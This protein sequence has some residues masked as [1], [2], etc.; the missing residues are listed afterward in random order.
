VQIESAL[1]EGDKVVPNL[2]SQIA[3]GM[4]VDAHELDVRLAGS[5]LFGPHGFGV[6]PLCANTSM[7]ADQAS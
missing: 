2:S 1:K 6:S 4:T 7:C 5:A 3:S